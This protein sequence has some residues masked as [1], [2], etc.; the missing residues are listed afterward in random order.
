MQLIGG[1]NEFTRVN[2]CYSRYCVITLFLLNFITPFLKIRLL[3]R[4]NMAPM[5]KETKL[6]ACIKYIIIIPYLSTYVVF[7]TIIPIRGNPKEPLQNK[8]FHKNAIERIV[9]KLCSCKKLETSETSIYWNNSSVRCSSKSF[10]SH[11][12]QQTMKEC[13][14]KAFLFNFLIVMNF[15]PDFQYG[16]TE[17]NFRISGLRRNFATAAHCYCIE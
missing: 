2:R 15:N 16:I 6:M 1:H 4:D 14:H 8:I 11:N 13:S 12:F 9:L 17:I 7:N 3:Q 5:S 10:I